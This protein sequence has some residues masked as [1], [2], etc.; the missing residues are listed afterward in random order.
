MNP[1]T[2][3]NIKMNDG[4]MNGWC[5]TIL[6]INLTTGEIIRRKLDKKNA[7]LFLGGRGLN[8]VLVCNHHPG[9]F[10]ANQN[11]ECWLQSKPSIFAASDRLLTLESNPYYS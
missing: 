1:S 10:L 9:K 7:R 5:G 3:W 8:Y 6:D 11:M 2:G 4:P